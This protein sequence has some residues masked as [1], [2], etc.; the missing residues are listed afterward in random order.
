MVTLT[1]DPLNPQDA[2]DAVLSE[3]DGAYLLFVGVVRDHARGRSVT[4]LEYQVY[5]PLARAQMERIVA[6]VRKTWNLSCAIL[7]RYGTL[8]IG[9]ASVVVC[10]ASPHRAEAFTACQWAIDTLKKDVPI[11]KKEFATDGTYW[12]EGDEALPAQ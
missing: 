5:P 10:V 3:A 9:E 2:V 4:G 12:I 7:H 6:Q 11:W 8:R 1:E